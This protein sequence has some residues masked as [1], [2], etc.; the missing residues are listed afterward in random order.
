MNGDLL[1]LIYS[2]GFMEG[3]LK[4]SPGEKLFFQDPYVNI[5]IFGLQLGDW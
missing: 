3:D 4:I 1:Q 5:V 2:L